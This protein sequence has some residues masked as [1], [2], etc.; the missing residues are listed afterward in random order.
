M[1]KKLSPSEKFGHQVMKAA[2]DFFNTIIE[3]IRAQFGGAII[4]LTARLEKLEGRVDDI[5]D[6]P[7]TAFDPK[8]FLKGF[9]DRAQEIRNERASLNSLPNKKA[10]EPAIP[11]ASKTN[12]HGNGAHPPA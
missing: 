5:D 4:A 10:E 2:Y 1:T 12:G 3:E 7:M 11:P 8:A 6:R 9:A